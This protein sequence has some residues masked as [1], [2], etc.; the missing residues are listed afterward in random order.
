MEEIDKLYERLIINDGESPLLY[1][2]D[3]K[4]RTQ[5]YKKIFEDL[6]KFREQQRFLKSDSDGYREIDCQIRLRLLKEIQIII[7]EYMMAK[8]SQDINR[9]RAMYGDIEMYKRNFFFYRM[10]M[11]YE[12]K[13]KVLTD[14]RLV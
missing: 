2:I 10:G 8:D 12:A 5:I 3:P 6:D 1:S 13:E 11:D 14:Y 4:V 7:D 9:W